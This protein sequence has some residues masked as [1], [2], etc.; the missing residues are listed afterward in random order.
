MIWRAMCGSGAPTGI[1]R[2]T[3][4][5]A[6]AKTRRVPSSASTRPSRSLRSGCSAAARSSA[7]IS[8]APAICRAGAER[9]RP[10]QEPATSDSAVSFRQR[11]NPPDPI[12]RDSNLTMRIHFA[13]AFI[14]FRTALVALI[15]A[16][17]ALS[18]RAARPQSAPVEKE[19]MALRDYG[20]K[21]YIRVS[22]DL[23]HR[24]DNETG[25]TRCLALGATSK[26]G[27]PSGCGGGEPSGDQWS[28]V[29]RQCWNRGLSK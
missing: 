12:Q 25:G 17:V 6:T 4:A 5:S 22:R 3:T 26:R 7:P 29:L 16:G 23:P 18:G 24:E 13:R 11:Q 21:K 9:A 27:S 15:L 19:S 1:V 8:T 28:I 2:T 14:V 10:I 20:L